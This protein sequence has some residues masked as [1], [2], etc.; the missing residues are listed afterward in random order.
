M[1]AS[2]QGGARGLEFFDGFS[3]ICL[4]CT[5]FPRRARSRSLLEDAAVPPWDIFYLSHGVSVSGPGRRSARA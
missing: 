5:F 4:E 1:C 2:D 3:R